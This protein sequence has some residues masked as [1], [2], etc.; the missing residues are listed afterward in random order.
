MMHASGLE[1]LFLDVDMSPTDD[2]WDCSCIFVTT[3]RFRVS[4]ASADL[5]VII[6]ISKQQL[7]IVTGSSVLRIAGALL[8]CLA[9]M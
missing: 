4:A 5:F 6:F 9:I 3:G 2:V 8:V 1:N 7:D